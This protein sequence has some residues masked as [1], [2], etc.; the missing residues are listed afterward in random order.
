MTDVSIPFLTTDADR[1][2][3]L[4]YQA[5]AREQATGAYPAEVL[6]ELSAN[7]TAVHGELVSAFDPVL[8]TNLANAAA[9]KHATTA[10]YW[11]N[12]ID[13]GFP[14]DPGVGDGLPDPAADNDPTANRDYALSMET[15]Y[16]AVA[17]DPGNFI[18]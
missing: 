1:H 14:A 18:P 8:A 15:T 5:A 13:F 16:L 7:I 11:Q 12:I 9:A 4:V 6:T 17:A 10:A 2:L 3:W